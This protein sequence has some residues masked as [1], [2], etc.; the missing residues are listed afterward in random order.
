MEYTH[1]APTKKLKSNSPWPEFEPKSPKWHRVC[2]HVLCTCCQLNSQLQR[3]DKE[4]VTE[5][6]EKEFLQQKRS[7]KCAMCYHQAH[8]PFLTVENMLNFKAKGPPN[9][10]KAG[11][12]LQGNH[13]DSG[14]PLYLQNLLISPKPFYTYELSDSYMT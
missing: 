9:L 13:L 6:Q 3:N 10:L 11:S 12:E 2:S 14:F 8:E 1:Y 4:N 7:Q 5:L